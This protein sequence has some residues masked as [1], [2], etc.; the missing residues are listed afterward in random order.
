[1]RRESQTRRSSAARVPRAQARGP[2][3]A[4]RPS[5]VEPVRTD[6]S[7]SRAMAEATSSR[8]QARRR[9]AE[10]LR[11]RKPPRRG[12]AVPVP[13]PGPGRTTAAMGGSASR[14]FSARAPSVASA[15]ASARAAASAF[16]W[17]SR[18]ISPLAASFS[19]ASRNRS[20]VSS[21][22]S[23]SFAV[24]SAS[25]S[26]RRASSRRGTLPRAPR[27]RR[28]IDPTPRPTRVS[29]PR[30]IPRAT[31]EVQPRHARAQPGRPRVELTRPARRSSGRRILRRA[32]AAA[33]VS[34]ACARRYSRAILAV[35]ARSPPPVA[36]S[37][38]ILRASLHL[39][40]RATA[41]STASFASNGGTPSGREETSKGPRAR[42]PTPL[43]SP[44]TLGVLDRVRAG[45]ARCPAT[46]A[47]GA[48]EHVREERRVVE[49]VRISRARGGE[50]RGDAEPWRHRRRPVGCVGAGCRREAVGRLGGRTRCHRRRP[51]RV[52]R[53]GRQRDA[54]T[55]GHTIV[56]DLGAIAATGGTR[57]SMVSRTRASSTQGAAFAGRSPKLRS[58]GLQEILRQNEVDVPAGERERAARPRSNPPTRAQS[59]AATR[60]RRSPGT[61]RDIGRDVIGRRVTRHA[62]TS[63]RRRDWRAA[64]RRRRRPRAPRS[65]R[66][67]A[68][69][70]GLAN[71]DSP[72]LIELAASRV[73]SKRA[74]ASSRSSAFAP[75]VL[76][77]ACAPLNLA[78][79]SSRPL[80][81]SLRRSRGEANRRSPPRR[82]ASRWMLGQRVAE[83]G[84]VLGES[85]ELFQRA[86]DAGAL[87]LRPPM[88]A[89]TRCVAV[90][91]GAA[92][93][94]WGRDGRADAGAAGARCHQNLRDVAVARGD[95]DV[96]RC[97]GGRGAERR[98]DEGRGRLGRPCSTRRTDET[99]RR[100]RG[101]IRG[102]GGGRRTGLVATQ[103]A[104][105]ARRERDVVRDIGISLTG[106][107]RPKLARAINAIKLFSQICRSYAN[108][109]LF[110]NFRKAVTQLSVALVRDAGSGSG[111]GS[112]FRGV[113]ILNQHCDGRVK[114]EPHLRATVANLC[115]SGASP[116]SVPS[117]RRRLSEPA[118]SPSPRRSYARSRRRRE[119]AAGHVEIA[120]E[121]LAL[122]SARSA[123][124]RAAAAAGTAKLELG[125]S[126]PPRVAMNA[127]TPTK[128]TS[129]ATAA[130]PPPSRAS[131][132]RGNRCG[133]RRGPRGRRCHRER[134]SC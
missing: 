3:P 125:P 116:A 118:L 87:V 50:S 120:G 73:A 86:R 81:L 53:S 12:P 1:M 20:R 15:S 45:A 60:R 43:S 67:E 129:P 98:R 2:V 74:S 108:T 70:R 58:A 41:L 78:L 35:A 26:R 105:D 132:W 36:L 14:S 128:T 69:E 110:A 62:R 85:L 119:V 24:S 55:P 123:M 49:L 10:T 23:L 54:T 102:R 9:R 89:A 75:R 94:G 71:S 5:R 99:A 40:R 44:S 56:E 11:R 88:F 100:K 46:R 84:I 29:P 131:S 104:R 19:R 22:S 52:L 93:R 13:V 66:P 121:S 21:I 48:A 79:S 80:S 114:K 107:Q 6:S 25:T 106:A 126:P 68:A 38:V 8:V 111:S 39:H 133:F 127:I 18:N 4:R 109:R 77:A 122:A 76:P 112:A 95:G 92:S 101:R 65:H 117:H 63:V 72:A 103:E 28:R 130:A 57:A 31:P 90:V 27:P 59:S 96:T 134:N 17:S 42:P 97:C 34:S 7:R 47:H 91:L 51:S 61:G 83:V 33:A 32:A 37:D 82:P 113:R 64:R 115:P 16:S 30:R 124:S